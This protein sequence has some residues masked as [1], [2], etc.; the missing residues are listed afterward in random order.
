[1]NKD[2]KIVQERQG[3]NATYGVSLC[4]PMGLRIGL[5]RQQIRN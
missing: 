4:N 3:V 1:M 2:I 5:T